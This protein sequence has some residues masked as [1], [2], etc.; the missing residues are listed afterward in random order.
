MHAQR[1]MTIN[2]IIGVL[3]NNVYSETPLVKY[4]LWW[5]FSG[6]R[7]FRF[8]FGYGSPAVRFIIF[9][10]AVFLGRERKVIEQ[11]PREA[12]AYKGGVCVYF[13]LTLKVPAVIIIK[14]LQLISKVRQSGRSGELRIWSLKT[15]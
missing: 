15:Y 6:F 3:F 8:N 5:S 12:V 7:L 14:F 4:L 2:K 1:N 13:S 11:A 10:L 9:F